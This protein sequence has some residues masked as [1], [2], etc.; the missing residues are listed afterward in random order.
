MLPGY[1]LSLTLC[2]GHLS[3]LGDGAT[4]GRRW[5]QEMGARIVGFILYLALS[6]GIIYLLISKRFLRGW[7]MKEPHVRA[8]ILAAI[9]LII[10]VGTTPVGPL[11]MVLMVVALVAFIDY[12]RSSEALAAAGDS[13]PS[14]DPLPS[15]VGA[16]GSLREWLTAGSAHDGFV[17]VRHMIVPTARR[18]LA[19]GVE[20][21]SAYVRSL[22]AREL[23][24]NGGESSAPGK[25][26]AAQALPDQDQPQP[27]P[28]PPPPLSIAEGHGL[29]AVQAA[30]APRKP[31]ARMP[32]R[33]EAKRLLDRLE[34]RA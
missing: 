16:I 8:A 23:V 22:T 21:L 13:A 10:A 26:H 33:D 28:P 15:L 1:C 20:K 32:T 5:A 6:Y 30:L 19:G 25:D 18:V 27:P 29:N 11:P 12:V 17:R 4:N 34:G 2:P 9:V 7:N 14:W 3:R 31:A 24:G